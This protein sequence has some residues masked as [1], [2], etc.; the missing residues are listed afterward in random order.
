MRAIERIELQA[1]VNR[2]E[3]LRRVLASPALA[4][5]LE[6]VV[7]L[8]QIGGLRRGG[9]KTGIEGGA[10]GIYVGPW[11]VVGTIGVLLRRGIAGGKGGA[12]FRIAGTKRLPRCAEID[13]YRRGI[14]AQIEVGRLDV[15]M[16]QLV[17]MHF[18]QAGEHAGENAAHELFPEA[19]VVFADQL[20]QRA[21][22]FV[23][24]HQI[25]RI[26]GTQEIE[27]A[28]DV[29]MVQTRQCNTFLVERHHA[30]LVGRTIFR[31][32]L[33]QQAD[34]ALCERLR[35]IFLDRHPLALRVARQIDN[36]K[37]P[38]RQ[39]AFEDIAVDDMTGRQRKVGLRRGHG[40][41]CK[42]GKLAG[43]AEYPRHFRSPPFLPAFAMTI[44]S[45][46]GYAAH[47]R[48]LG[49][50]SLHIELK[51]V[52]SRFLDLV[53]RCTDELRFLEMSLREKLNA[54]LGRGK[55]DVRLYLQMTDGTAG[56]APAPNLERVGQLIA[57]A[58][59]VR[60]VMPNATPLS[61]ADVLRWPGVLASETLAADRLQTE[62]ADLFAQVLADFV[63]SRAREGDRLAAV[64]RDRVA[65]MRAEVARVEPLVPL[66]IAEYS[67]RLASRLQE[68]VATLDEERIRQEIG[69]FATKIDVAEELARLVTHLNEVERVLDKGGAVGKRLDFLTQE[70][71]REANTLASK[72]VSAAVTAIALEL[73]LLIEQVREQV[74]NLE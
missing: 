74:Q 36:R 19:A 57:A 66:A 40:G 13:Q 2:V 72:S 62:S 32:H 31:P 46:T 23:A 61:V 54:R 59:S 33:R 39:L 15:E 11:A 38:R 65:R 29:R 18:A 26:V 7:K 20:V 52:N 12:Q 69:V 49:L 67:A 3:Q 73:K 28:H 41:H 63:A 4:G 58:E 1:L 34:A 42:T 24:H 64:L 35:Q 68:A 48:D 6:L 55:V 44:H 9:G 53:F 14:V 56:T 10:N 27:Y 51:S 25:N 17:G 5:R 43:L 22:F 16:Q 8:T 71:N 70:L 30:A 47:D 45:M 50:A 37:P 21:T 60:S